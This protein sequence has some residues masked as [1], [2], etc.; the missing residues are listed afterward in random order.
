MRE[1]DDRTAAKDS[2]EEDPGWHHWL[3]LCR[4]PL[5]VEVADSGISVVGIDV[6]EAKVK[7]IRGGNPIS[8]MSPHQPFPSTFSLVALR[9]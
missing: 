1:P 5:A 9:P 4:A 7:L 6:A 3:G 2:H 8:L